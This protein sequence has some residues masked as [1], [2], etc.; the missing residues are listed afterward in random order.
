WPFYFYTI[1]RT[2]SNDIL[3]LCDSQE[4]NNVYKNFILDVKNYFEY[5]G[6]K[7]MNDKIN[8]LIKITGWFTGLFFLLL[9]IV[10][11]TVWQIGWIDII[12][13][14]VTISTFITIGYERFMW[15]WKLFRIFNKQADISGDY[16]A[17]LRHFYGEGGIKKV[18]VEIKQT[19]LTVNIE[20]RSDEITS[21]SITADIIEEH[22]K[23]I[24]YYT[25]ITNPKAEFE[26]KNPINRGTTRLIVEENELTGKYWTG[27]ETTGDLRLKKLK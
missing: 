26:K 6:E 8:H 24:L 27:A 12:S 23:N 2:L 9:I 5:S 22:G 15:K 10:S 20:F 11:C 3:Y 19:F 16:E 13:Y 4:K 21:N 18:S 25:Y 1:I 17:T 14:T 7:K